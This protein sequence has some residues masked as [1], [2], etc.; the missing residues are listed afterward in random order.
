MISDLG[1]EVS[2]ASFG[3]GLSY[4]SFTYRNL[5]LSR[6][7]IDD[8]NENIIATVELTNGGERAGRESVLW[9]VTDEV[10]SITRPVKELKHFEKQL[11]APGETRKFTF[12]LN[13]LEHLSFPDPTGKPIIEKGKFTIRVGDLL[14][15]IEYLE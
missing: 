5:Q 11:I 8:I 2:M 7:V 1:K 6:S 15:Q 3:D 12:V 13:P 9:Y 4:T 10:G 14:A